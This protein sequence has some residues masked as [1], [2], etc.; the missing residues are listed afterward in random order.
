[1]SYEDE[2]ESMSFS[3]RSSAFRNVDPGKVNVVKSQIELYHAIAYTILRDTQSPEEADRF[4]QMYYTDLIRFSLYVMKLDGVVAKQEA[5]ILDVLFGGNRSVRDLEK[6]TAHFDRASMEAYAS[7]VPESAAVLV[8]LFAGVGDDVFDPM[9][10]PQLYLLVAAA[11]CAADGSIDDSEI[12]GVNTFF[13]MLL[14]YVGSVVGEA[15]AVSSEST[16]SRETALALLGLKEEDLSPESIK[17]AYRNAMQLNH[18][19]RF[20]GDDNLRAYAEEQCRQINEARDLLMRETESVKGSE[21]H[22]VDHGSK[23]YR[24][25]AAEPEQE[26]SP[27]PPRTSSNDHVSSDDERRP[28]SEEPSSCQQQVEV[29]GEE[30]NPILSAECPAIASWKTSVGLSIVGVL[31][32]VVL[33][34]VVVGGLAI[35]LLISTGIADPVYIGALAG[36]I[37]AFFRD[38]I[39][40]IYTRKFYPS[41][42]T[43]TPRLKSSRAIS[44]CNVLFGSIVFGSIWNSNLTRSRK[45]GS[46]YKGISYTVLTVLLSISMAVGLIGVVATWSPL[47]RQHASISHSQVSY[48][49]Y[50]AGYSISYP[51]SW[52]SEKIYSEDG[53]QVW[54]NLYPK[55]SAKVV[56]SVSEIGALSRSE[57]AAFTTEGAVAIGAGM[58]N[59]WI[60]DSAWKVTLGGAEYWDVV[61]YGDLNGEDD[62][63]TVKLEYWLTSQNN[64]AYLFSCTDYYDDSASG[65][66][67]AEFRSIIASAKYMAS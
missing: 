41:Y 48:N 66:Y 62:T 35:P 1:M 58:L 27:P 54:L 56:A 65:A 21:G 67:V 60:V 59:N 28:T 6:I 17:K 16:M 14:S 38:A 8:D 52:A 4:S 44:F 30:K 2:R 42:F 15:E 31:A 24:Y 9:C 51:D 34:L 23:G 63:I 45:E 64:K 40:L 22:K 7:R 3:G 53:T 50:E 46:P 49:D 57:F 13:D 32:E 29:S 26:P 11:I 10:V 61:G 55:K 47:L 43:R 12:E 5:E 37:V 19:D 18:P 39:C 33:W 36:Q 25:N 20:L